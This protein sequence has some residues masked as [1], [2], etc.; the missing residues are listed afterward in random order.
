MRNY[1]GPYRLTADLC[2]ATQA[3]RAARIAGLDAPLAALEEQITAFRA[4]ALPGPASSSLSDLFSPL[5]DLDALSWNELQPAL[6]QCFKGAAAMLQGR[7][8]PCPGELA[9]EWASPPVHRHFSLLAFKPWGGA[10]ALELDRVVDMGAGG[11]HVSW[12]PTCGI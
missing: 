11:L 12:Y 2:P 4:A 3:R 9:V 7:G 5:A 8:G 1:F 10:R 6:L